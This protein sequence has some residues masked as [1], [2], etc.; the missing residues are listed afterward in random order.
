M[1]KHNCLLTQTQLYFRVKTTVFFKILLR[2]DYLDARL[3]SVSS[4][5]ILRIRI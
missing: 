4:K 2:D 5:M 1:A 3:R